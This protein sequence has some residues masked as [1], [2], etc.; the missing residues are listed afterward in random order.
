MVLKIFRNMDLFKR[1]GRLNFKYPMRYLFGAGLA[2]VSSSMA[3][4]MIVVWVVK[5]FIPLEGT[6]FWIVI[7]LIFLLLL[8]LSCVFIFQG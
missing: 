2:I 8:L 7:A 6:Y 3:Y 5:Y 4:A 1:I